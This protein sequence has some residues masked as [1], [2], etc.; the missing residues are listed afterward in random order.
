MLELENI[1]GSTLE[2]NSVDASNQLA[3]SNACCQE[4]VC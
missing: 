4:F 3:C 2:S 1:C